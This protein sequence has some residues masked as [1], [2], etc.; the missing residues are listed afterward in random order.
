MRP[1]IAILFV[2]ALVTAGVTPAHAATHASSTGRVL[3][4]EVA[5]GGSHSE[6]DSFFELRNWGAKAVDLTGWSVYRCSEQGLRSNLGRTEGELSGVVLEPGEIYTVSKVGM[7]GDASITQPFSPLGFGLYLATPKGERADSV[8]VYPNEPWPTQSECSTTGNLPN[9]LAFAFDESWQRVAATGDPLRDFVV[10]PMTLGAANARGAVPATTGVIIDEFASSGPAATDDE[11]VELVNSSSAAVDISG[12]ELYRCDARGRLNPSDRLTSITADTVLAPGQRYLLAGHGYPRNSSQT[13]DGEFA[14]VESG[15]LLRTADGA[16][17]DRV[18]VTSYIDSACQGDEKLEA[19]VDF[20]NAESY[21]RADLTNA[22][23]ASASA[24]ASAGWIVAPRTPATSN[25]TRSYALA[26]QRFA[27]GARGVAISEVATDPA[28]AQLP[29]GV[30]QRN[31]IE[32]ANYGTAAVDISGWTLRRCEASGIRSRTPQVTIADGTLLEPGAAW[33]AARAGTPL[34]SA[35]NAT[36]PHALNMLGAGVWLADARGGRIDS[37]G[38]YAANE[39]DAPNVVAS[40]CTKGAALT[41]Y[42][43]DRMLAETFQRTRFTGVD[44]DDFVTA[45]ATPGAIDELDWVDP[46]LRVEGAV[47]IPQRA[48]D[49]PAPIDGEALRVLGT[50]SGV[51]AGP[52][53][54]L[55]GEHETQTSRPATAHGYEYPYQRFLLDAA[56]L[57]AGATV[58]WTGSSTGSNEVQF[59]V[60]TGAAWRLLQ[61]G[62]G[63]TFQLAGVLEAGEI[64]DGRVTLLAQDGPRTTPRLATDPDGALQHPS[65]YDLAI[66]HITD[67]QYLSESY[68]E[69]YAELVS[70]IAD[71][72]EPRKIAFATHTGDLVQNWV[73][74]AQNAERA[75]I[76]FERASKIQ[77]I[78]DDAGVPNSVLPGNHDNKRG[79]DDDLFNEYFPPS[80]YD[81]APTYG[82]SIAPDDNSANYSTFE[83]AGARFLMLSLPYAYGEREIAW[84]SRVVT[85]HKSYNVIISTH[86]HVTPKTDIEGA[87]RSANSRWLSRGQHLWERVIAPNRNVGI[88]LSGHFH[89]IGQIRTENAGGIEGH[90]VVELLADY[91]EFR[92]HTGERAT[93]F[94]RLLQI[95]LASSTVAVDTF[96][97]RLD[98]AASFDYDYPQFVPDTGLATSQSNVRPWNL[99]SAGLQGRYTADDDEFTASVSF[100]YAKRVATDGITVDEPVAPEPADAP[101]HEAGAAWALF[102]LAIS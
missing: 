85:S 64:V 34:A 9:R 16:L 18:A 69:V 38:I 5:N 60:W 50:W 3:I 8:A 13:Y 67:T 71:N 83:R 61:A 97:V 96:S 45:E 41:T 4:N 42:Q 32:I 90:D 86:E 84:A 73:D 31:Y 30:D 47:A 65:D 63:D 43:P 88:V 92:T 44:A 10:A 93:G 20:V 81:S 2:L 75:T 54:T 70:W 89:G 23:S 95:D 58:R 36:Y 37:V 52:L 79:V 51:S 6:S 100:Q 35:S 40:P 14:D 24:S 25:R 21:Q 17:A 15:V 87:H 26:D 77:A 78:L 82:G 59:S 74:P 91:Q 80:R 72:A 19:A 66:S 62:S 22:D 99:V 57:R 76:E 102:G 28:L 94:Q 101:E 98:A 53:A 39:M 56:G 48:V 27:Y 55:R 11:F 7:D 33:I 68:P 12:W 1:W 49:A 29:A 46:T